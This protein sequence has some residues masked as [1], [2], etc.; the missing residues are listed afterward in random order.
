MGI[1]SHSAIGKALESYLTNTIFV[2]DLLRGLRIFLI[3]LRVC[4][5]PLSTISAKRAEPVDDYGTFNHANI[6][7]EYW[8]VVGGC[9]FGC[10]ESVQVPESFHVG[11]NP[12][13]G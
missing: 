10:P 8:S 2:T 13:T 9:H 12:E 1:A 4:Q 11:D 6:T 5:L 7:Y 3:S